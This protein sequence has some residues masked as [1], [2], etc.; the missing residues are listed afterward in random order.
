M[1]LNGPIAEGVN[2]V[3]NLAGAGAVA[4][5][6]GVTCRFVGHVLDG[7]LAGTV[8]WGEAN[9]L[10]GCGGPTSSIKFEITGTRS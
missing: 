3:A 1:T 6:P 10:P 8:T 7:S 4:G 2:G 9:E 5:I